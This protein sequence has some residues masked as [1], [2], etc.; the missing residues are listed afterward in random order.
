MNQGDVCVFEITYNSVDDNLKVWFSKM[1]NVEV[2]IADGFK[3]HPYQITGNFTFVSLLL[4][5][6]DTFEVGDYWYN[7][8]SA[9]KAYLFI[10]CT[11]TYGYAS[12]S[13]GKKGLLP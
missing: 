1:T 4:K 13:Y 12:F 5:S 10:K 3:K 9:G 8:T 7:I 2:T 6:S 11:S